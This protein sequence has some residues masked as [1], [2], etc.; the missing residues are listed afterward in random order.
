MSGR[1][2][3]DNSAPR[4]LAVRLGAMG[5][6]LHALPAVASLKSSFQR[7]HLTWLVEPQWAA[8][9]EGN[10]FVDRVVLFHRGSARAWIENWR[11][12]RGE[13]FDIAVDFQGLIK[14]AVAAR[15]TRAERTFGF[16]FSQLRE[17][18][19]AL[20]YSESVTSQARHVVDKNLELA[21]AA[22]ASNMLCVFPVP[23][24]R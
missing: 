7:A 9:L 12:L 14:S 22:G 10:P 5:D 6:I 16:H 13:R 17:R 11:R 21:A 15:M 2:I 4:I 23:P 8:L 24:G 19:A 20:L 3:P 1:A 18:P